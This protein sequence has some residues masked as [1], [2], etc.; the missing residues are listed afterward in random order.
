MGYVLQQHSPYHHQLRSAVV[1][2]Y[3]HCGWTKEVIAEHFGNRPNRDT[4][5]RII[6]SYQEAGGQVLALAGRQ[7]VLHENRKFDCLAREVLVDIVQEEERSRL[8]GALCC[9]RHA[10]LCCSRHVRPCAMHIHA[11]ARLT[12]LS[13]PHNTPHRHCRAHDMPP[14][15]PL[16]SSGRVSGF[17]GG[18]L[19]MEMHGQPG[20]RGR[21]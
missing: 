6:R 19:H 12:F 16:V 8:Q 21:P 9:S 1:H 4:V 5:G 2:L 14:R 13:P 15:Q 11:P 10:Q 3:V 7:G 17:E 20:G 18:W